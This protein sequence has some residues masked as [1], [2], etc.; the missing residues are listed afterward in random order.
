MEKEVIMHGLDK[1]NLKVQLANFINDTIR[2]R[3]LTQKQAAEDMGISQPR[4]SNLI[5]RRMD[6]FSL[7]FLVDM[8]FR[9]GHTIKLQPIANVS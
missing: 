2:N 6:S 9:L 8:V 4:L 3:K 7:D 1:A 5:N